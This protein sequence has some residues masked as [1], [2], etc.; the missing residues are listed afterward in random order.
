MRALVEVCGDPGG[1]LI[2]DVGTGAGYTAFVMARAGARVIGLDPTHEMLLA[3]RR[4]WRDRGLAGKALLA[5]AWAEQ[6]PL[7]DAVLDAVVAHRAPHQFADPEAFVR[8]AH[9]L[10][11]PG[12]ILAV[13]DQ[14]PPDGMQGWHDELERL[15]DPTHGWA[16]SP[17]E[18]RR[19]AEEAGFAWERSV[20]VAQDHDVEAWLDRVDASGEQRA[21]CIRMLSEAPAP[22]RA[23]YGIEERD[24]RLVMRTPQ[25]VFAAR[26]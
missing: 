7:R 15:R 12:G 23:A 11:R 2:L 16:L 18:W 13:G 8:E 10:V 24:G 1:K 20:L 19:I 5:E 25:L 14:S 26:R 4:G 21:A 6:L 3:S 9:R 22:V 17:Q